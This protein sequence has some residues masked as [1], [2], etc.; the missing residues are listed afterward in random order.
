MDGAFGDLSETGA[1]LAHGTEIA[2]CD[3]AGRNRCYPRAGPG[4]DQITGTKATLGQC[5]MGQT[6][7]QGIKNMIPQQDGGIARR[8]H[9]S[10]NG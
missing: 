1:D 7:G 6:P 2:H 8:R 9:L 10:I 3:I 4:H 5:G